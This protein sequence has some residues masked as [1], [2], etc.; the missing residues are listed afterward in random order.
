MET[1]VNRFNIFKFLLTD[2]LKMVGKDLTTLVDDDNWR[3]NNTL[4]RNE[5][6]AFRSDAISL[7]KKTFKCNRTKALN[8]FEWY[9]SNFGLRLK[10]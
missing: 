1:T 6:S 3:F 9:W 7:I 8:T 4:T 10:N 5:F 2:E